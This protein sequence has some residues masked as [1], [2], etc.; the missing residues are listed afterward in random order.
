VLQTAGDH[1]EAL[2]R[3]MEVRTT[4]GGAISQVTPNTS[5]RQF[6]LRSALQQWCWL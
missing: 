4:K 6:C 3:D 1:L 2:L 5:W